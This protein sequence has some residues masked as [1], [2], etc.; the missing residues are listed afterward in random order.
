[1]HST[2]S[3]GSVTVSPPF[4]LT[5]AISEVGLPLIHAYRFL[6]PLDQSVLSFLHGCLNSR[7][8]AFLYNVF[9]V[10]AVGLDDRVEVVNLP[11]PCVHC[12]IS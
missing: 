7:V 2:I 1:M 10:A 11:R 6:P 3:V 4:V 12:P 8:W 5:A 9:D